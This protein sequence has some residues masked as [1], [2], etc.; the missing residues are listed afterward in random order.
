MIKN[1]AFLAVDESGAEQQPDAAALQ[2]KL[3]GLCML[4]LG[5][6]KTFTKA[7]D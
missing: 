4:G 7:S 2:V 3:K 1:L 6:G 5:S